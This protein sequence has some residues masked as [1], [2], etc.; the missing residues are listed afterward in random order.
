MILLWDL[1]TP[2]FYNKTEIDAFG[3]ELPALILNTCTKTEVE[4]LTSNVNLVYYTKAEIDSQL[5]DYTTKQKLHQSFVTPKQ[6]L[7]QSFVTP[8]L[9]YTKAEIDSQLTDYTTITHL[10]GNY[11]TTLAIT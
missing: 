3:G 9:C 6:K 1:D 4:G 5:T 10:Q 7:H 11:M 2:N 8:K